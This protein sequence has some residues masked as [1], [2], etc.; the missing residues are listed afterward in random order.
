MKIFDAVRTAALDLEPG[1][2]S[3]A[4]DAEVLMRHLL[5]WNRTEYLVRRHEPIEDSTL[6]L[7]RALIARRAQRE[8]V[9]YIVGS[10]EFMGLPYAVG[11]GA[12]VP[13]PE[14]ELLVEWAISWLSDK[15]DRVA[16]DVG[17]GSGAI[18]VAVARLAP[19]GS[20][21]R[22]I[23]IDPSEDALRWARTN[24]ASLA[25]GAPIQVVPGSLLDEVTGPIDLVLANLPYLTPEQT[26]DNPDLVAE[27]RSALVSGVDGLDLIRSLLADLP[28][29]L[30]LDGAA[31]LE[32]DPDQANTVAELARSVFPDASVGIVPD[33][34]RRSRFVTIERGKC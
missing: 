10:R 11:P 28:R 17:T 4:L 26:D 27:P 6:R 14:T 3:P 1:S 23:A 18:A 25:P 8:P 13:R 16:V 32:L 9:A 19:P 24:A 15:H 12:L 21:G 33:L 31:I 7:Y 5:G 29:V 30:A 20:L 22:L 2:E 34:S